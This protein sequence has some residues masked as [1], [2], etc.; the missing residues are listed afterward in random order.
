MLIS[1]IVENIAKKQTKEATQTLLSEMIATNPVLDFIMRLNDPDDEAVK[2]HGIPKDYDPDVMVKE[3]TAFGRNIRVFFNARTPFGFLCVNPSTPN[4][5]PVKKAKVF[6]NI[7]NSIP[8]SELQL[9][10]TAHR[11]ELITTDREYN[12]LL[13]IEKFTEILAILGDETPEKPVV[14]PVDVSKQNDVLIPVQ[15]VPVS[16]DIVAPTTSTTLP[17]IPEV[18]VVTATS[19]S[20]VQLD[21]PTIIPSTLEIPMEEVPKK[22]RGRPKMTDEQKAAAKKKREEKKK[23]AKK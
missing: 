9:L 23:K 13:G 21:P 18:P 16:Q 4:F 11:N 5:D 3:E 1:E 14:I 20:E 7:A 19:L 12:N 22:K 17:Q 6:K 8:T 2:F 10:L 15:E